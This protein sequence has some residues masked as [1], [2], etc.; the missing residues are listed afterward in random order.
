MTIYSATIHEQAQF[1]T[2][3]CWCDFEYI[4]PESLMDTARGILALP[5]PEA[6]T[7]AEQHWRELALGE[8]LRR[9]EFAVERLM[10]TVRSDAP[11]EFDIGDRWNDICDGLWFD[12]PNMPLDERQGE[13]RRITHRVESLC[14][15]LVRQAREVGIQVEFYG[16]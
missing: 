13:F 9:V 15:E 5:I 14:R 1:A 8:M 12:L 10:P 16:E 2:P 7:V 4:R 11:H 6:R 3:R